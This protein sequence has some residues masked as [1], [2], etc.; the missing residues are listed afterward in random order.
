VEIMQ[1]NGPAL[2]L[3]R[4]G[5]RVVAVLF[6]LEG[7]TVRK[8]SF[9][10]VSGFPSPV[11]HTVSELGCI[12]GEELLSPRK[13]PCRHPIPQLGTPLLEDNSAELFLLNTVLG[14]PWWSSG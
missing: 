6:L 7:G 8:V 13:S 14:P 2:C 3:A 10:L 12:I 4:G 5:H 1:V 11:S 9:L